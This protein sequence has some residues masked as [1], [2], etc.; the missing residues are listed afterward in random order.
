MKSLREIAKKSSLSLDDLVAIEEAILQT[1]YMTHEKALAEID[2]FAVGLG[3]DDYYFKTTSIE[4]MVKHLIAISAS[5]LV[6]KYGGVGVGIDLINEESDRALYIVEESKIQEIEDRIESKYPNFRVESYRTLKTAIDKHL[7][8]YVVNRPVFKKDLPN[9][10]EVTFEQ[11]SS[12]SFFEGRGPET[13]QR[14]K[15]A[16]DWMNIREAPYIS[17]SEKPDT[18]E[19]R[20]MVGIHGGGARQFMAKFTI[21]MRKHDL[22]SNRKY[23]EPFLDDKNIYTFYYHKLEP[24]IVEDFY[25]EINTIVML[26]EHPITE[27]FA[28]G[29][30]SSQTAMYAISAAAFANQFITALTDEYT[31]LSRALKEQ[32][33]AKGILD[34]IKL[35]LV[36]DTFTESKIAQVVSEHH[37]IIAMLYQDFVNRLDPRKRCGEDRVQ[38]HVEQIQNA[39]ETKVSASSDKAIL[40][41]FLPFNELVLKTNFFRR[42]KIC[43]VYRLDPSFLNQIDYPEKPFGIF[44]CVGRAFVGFHV[45][46]RDIAR[47]GIRIVKSRSFSDYRQN[48]DTTF[49]ENYNLALTQQ[50]KNKDIPEGGSKGIILLRLHNQDEA[51]RAF[52]DYVDGILDVLIPH[53]D[54]CDLFGQEEILFFGPDERTADLMD[55]VPFYGKKQTYPFWK[56]LSTG[57]APENGGIPHDLYGMTTASVHQYVLGCLEKLGIEEA[58]VTKIQ[59]GGPDG[60]LGSNEIKVSKD[61]TIAVVDG[62]GVLYDPAGINR[63]GLLSLANQRK[64]VEHFDQSLLT[65]EG[66]FVSINDKKVTLPDGTLVANGEEFRNTFHLHPLAKADLFVPCGGRPAAVNINNWQQLFEKDGSAKFKIIVE[67]ANLFIT[68]EARLRLEEHDVVVI[69][70]ASA[71]KG[72]VTSSS[73]EVFASLA[74]SDE[75]FEKNFRV[76]NGD[77]PKFMQ[78]YV[79]EIIQ[80]VKDNARKEFEVLWSE[81]AKTGQPFTHLTNIVSRK[82]NDLTDSI[83]NSELPANPQLKKKLIEDYAPAS[84]LELVGLDSIL[85]RVPENYLNAIV[86]T[87]LATGFVYSHGLEGNEIDFYTYLQK[88]VS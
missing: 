15:E 81:N 74:L 76:K 51:D 54:V 18:Q 28:K 3:L 21:Q 42:D 82:I 56:A 52:K 75:E 61:K 62:S 27:L 67:G 43:A 88:F 77:I 70:D 41:Y 84:L 25:R 17:I 45:R 5:E 85:E 24:E 8:L 37:E 36:K 32:P 64:M 9:E 47:G 4:E 66:F 20:V 69:K 23:K 34:K 33:E 39:I 30:F 79:N 58:A 22:I 7:R 6:S 63:E 80:T 1:G 29:I 38:A 48:L 50:K 11:A 31:T 13:L 12:L 19:T 40:Q 60:D 46:F 78:Q 83:F 73:L 57:K 55:W 71:N 86:A 35:R 68:E 53:E 49:M 26:P 2:N 16:W 87:R 72:G 59:T 14:Y 65:A 44:F 10:M